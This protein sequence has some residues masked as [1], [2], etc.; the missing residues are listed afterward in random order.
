[1][2]SYNAYILSEKI[3]QKLLNIFPPLFSTTKAHHSTYNYGAK[4]LED[5]SPLK[6]IELT[7]H[8]TDGHGLEVLVLKIDGATL[9]K[10]G[11]PFHVTWS[12][13]SNLEVCADLHAYLALDTPRPYS[14]KDSNDLIRY[15]LSDDCPDSFTVTDLDC[16]LPP[17]EFS[18]AYMNAGTIEYF[19]VAP[20][21]SPLTLKPSHTPK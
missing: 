11:N 18:P 21:G 15:A 7:H 1:M 5:I 19:G 13:D 2:H 9:N 10:N 8:I 16:A 4:G 17:S 12:M 3:R 14:A 6:S 20:I